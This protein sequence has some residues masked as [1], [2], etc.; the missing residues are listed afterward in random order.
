MLFLQVLI[1]HERSGPRFVS[2]LLF[3]GLE[4]ENFW[5]FREVGCSAVAYKNKKVFAVQTSE[6]GTTML[7]TRRLNNQSTVKV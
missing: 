7:A 6:R 2:D 4:P 1:L 5:L 3:Q